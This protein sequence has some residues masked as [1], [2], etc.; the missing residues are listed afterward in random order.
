MPDS[1]SRLD[2]LGHRGGLGDLVGVF[3]ERR[4]RARVALTDQVQLAA[5]HPAAG[6]GDDAVGQRHHLRRR[7]VVAFEAHHG[8]VGKAPREV[9]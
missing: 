2:V 5:G 9:E 4:R 7:A 8:R 6:G 3:G 1:I